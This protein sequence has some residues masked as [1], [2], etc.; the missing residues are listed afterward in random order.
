[1]NWEKVIKED[2]SMEAISRSVERFRVLCKVYA[3]AEIVPE[4]V[5][6]VQY[7]VQFISIFMHP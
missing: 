6:L 3:S 5:V 1:M 7:T 2:D 4:F